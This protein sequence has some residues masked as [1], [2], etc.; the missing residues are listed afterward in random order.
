MAQ[1]EIDGLR[2]LLRS[3]PRPVGWAER[4]QRLDDIGSV[5][6][7]ADDVK[8]ESVDVD[9]LGGEWSIA[10]NSDPS[11]VLMFF[12]GGGYCSGSIVS[13]RRMVTEAGRAAG[14]R[15]LAVAYRLAPEHPFPAAYADALTAWRFLQNEGIPAGRIALGGDSAG[16]G[17]AV[18][19]IGQLRDAHEELPACVWLVSPWTDLTMS[20][21]SLSSKSAADPIIHQQYLNELADAY[22]PSGMDRKDLRVSPLYADLRSFPPLLI[23]VGSAE[24]LLNDA[25]RFASAAGAADVRVTLEIWPHMIHAWHLWNAHLEPGRRALA[26]AGAFLRAHMS[27]SAR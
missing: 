23:Q 19:L 7:V 2:A 20:G 5:W 10:P 8:L 18:G 21:S 12:H 6:P 15:T 13:H 4:R 24:T 17:L 1:S 14:M 22:L 3:K 25:T 27:N 9:A 26:S 11:R 16:A